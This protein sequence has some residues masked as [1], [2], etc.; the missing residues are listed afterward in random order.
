MFLIILIAVSQCN[1]ISNIWTRLKGKFMHLHNYWLQIEL[2][3]LHEFFL[4]RTLISNSFK[5]ITN[6]KELNK[7]QEALNSLLWFEII[8]IQLIHGLN[9]SKWK[10]CWIGSKLRFHFHNTRFRLLDKYN[11]G[12]FSRLCQNAWCY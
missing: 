11:C 7:F 2:L 4:S 1:I 12:L 6:L 3:K 8:D 5:A 9:L 10:I